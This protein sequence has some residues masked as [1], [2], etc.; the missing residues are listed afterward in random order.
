[1]RGTHEIQITNTDYFFSITI[2]RNYL[3]GIATRLIATHDSWRQHATTLISHFLNGFK[4]YF[5]CYSGL[6]DLP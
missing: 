2:D 1:M 6:A 5:N 3:F 4:P